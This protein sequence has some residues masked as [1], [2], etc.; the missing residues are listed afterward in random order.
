MSATDAR[1]RF[2]DALSTAARE[3][4]FITRHGKRVA[5]LVT[6]DFYERAAEALEDAA[7]VAAAQAALDE[8]GDNVPWEVVKAELGLA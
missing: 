3:P 6:A 2:S 8:D 4:V 5:A 1:E 7:D